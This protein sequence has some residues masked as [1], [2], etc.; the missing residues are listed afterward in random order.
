MIPK[1]QR[2]HEVFLP[3]LSLILTLFLSGC[4]HD[5]EAQRIVDKSI[6]AHWGQGWDT[7]EME[8]RF[9]DINYSLVRGST[10]F[11]YSREFF[12][13]ADRKIK[14]VLTDRSF[15]RYVNDEAIEISPSKERA[16]SNSVNSVMYFNLLPVVLNDPAVNKQLIGE[17]EVKGEPYFLL[18]I[19]FQE[20]G[21]GDDFDDLYL[22][23]INRET[24]L[25][26][27]LAYEFHVDGGGKRFREA[28]NRRE[29][30]GV[31]FQDYKNFKADNAEDLFIVDG[32]FQEGKLEL[33][34][35]IINENLKI[36]LN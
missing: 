22:Y 11:V 10:G 16:Y 20:E 9:R 26:D 13:S 6:G 8:F 7:I 15:Q 32:L 3:A 30:N 12:D 27:Y 28:I 1:F 34:S 17:V 24:Y 29:V 33:L 18:Q 19:T 2:A 14:D 5:N 25:I 4:G 21:G 23:W 36:T 31:W 35:E